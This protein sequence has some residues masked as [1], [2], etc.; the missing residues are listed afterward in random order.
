MKRLIRNSQV[1]Y[2]TLLILGTVAGCGANHESFEKGEGSEG[3]AS[4]AIVVG[5]RGL[6]ARGTTLMAGLTNGEVRSYPFNGVSYYDARGGRIALHP[7]VAASTATATHWFPGTW[8]RKENDDLVYRTSNGDLNMLVYREGRGTTSTI[9]NGWNFTHYVAGHFVDGSMMDLLTRDSAGVATIYSWGTTGPDTTAWIGQR[10]AGTLPDA[11]FF[12]GDFD[13]DGRTDLMARLPNGNLDLYRFNGTAFVLSP[14]VGQGWTGFPI[15]PGDFDGDGKT[16]IL[17]RSPWTGE[18]FMFPFLGTNFGAKVSYGNQPAYDLGFASDFDGDGK[19]D[20]LVRSTTKDLNLY[21]SRGTSL[22]AARQVGNGWDFP[23]LLLGAFETGPRLGA[24]EIGGCS[25]TLVDKGWALANSNCFAGSATPSRLDAL[26]GTTVRA[27]V[28]DGWHDSEHDGLLKL[29]AGSLALV[30]LRDAVPPS[31]VTTGLVT[32]FASSGDARL[33]PGAILRCSGRGVRN[34]GETKPTLLGDGTWADARLRIDSSSAE[35]LFLGSTNGQG[36]AAGDE[37][38][39]CTFDDGSLLAGIVTTAASGGSSQT[40]ATSVAGASG[41]IAKQ[42]IDGNGPAYFGNDLLLRLP[43]G[44]LQ[45]WAWDGVDYGRDKNGRQVG[46][47]WEGMTNLYPGT[48]TRHGR[49]DLAARSATGELWLYPFAGG[50]FGARKLIASTWNYTHTLVGRFT[51]D[52]D[53]DVITRNASGVLEHRSFTNGAFSLPTT[54]LASAPYAEL[55]AADL[56]G[57]GTSDV[58]ARDSGGTL[59]KLRFDPITRTFATPSVIG[60]GFGGIDV[61]VGDFNR[62]GIA[63][64]LGRNAAGEVKLYPFNGTKFTSDYG[65]LVGTGWPAGARYV[66]SDFDHDGRADVLAFTGYTTK[67]A[68]LRT[69]RD[70]YFET[71]Q[72]MDNL[73]SD[74]VVLGSWG[75]GD[76]S[77][78]VTG[79]AT[80]APIGCGSS[81]VSMPFRFSSRDARDWPQL[82]AN[83]CTSTGC[84]G[85]NAE[86]RVNILANRYVSK[87][88]LRFPRLSVDPTDLLRVEVGSQAAGWTLADQRTGELSGT[89]L[90]ASQS[91]S[92]SMTARPLRVTLSAGPSGSAAG[93]EVD[94]V[95]LQCQGDNPNPALLEMHERY[96]GVLL[97]T[98][99][100]VL[101]RFPVRD[102]HQVVTMWATDPSAGTDF[103][104]YARC[105]A[106]PTPTEYDF[107]SASGRADETIHFASTER[108]ACTAGSWYVA[109]HSRRG[110]GQFNL[111][112]TRHAAAQHREVHVGITAYTGDVHRGELTSQQAEQLRLAARQLFSATEGQIFV[113]NFVLH[114]VRE[115]VLS[116]DPQRSDGRCGSP[117]RHCDTLYVWDDAGGTTKSALDGFPSSFIGFRTTPLTVAHEWLHLWGGRT[118]GDGGLVDE[119]ILTGG[120]TGTGCGHSNMAFDTAAL[121]T[122]ADH[123]RDL[124]A[125]TVASAAVAKSA[126]SQLYDNGAVLWKPTTTPDGFDYRDHSF[127]NEQGVEQVGRVTWAP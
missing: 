39:P 74:D 120:S 30:R 42:I 34:H 17:A 52:S 36:T 65:I 24:A 13:G 104:L 40:Q 77:L 7:S 2:S 101:A 99:D 56:D 31:R 29:A 121:C 119:Y 28:A 79:A 55:W 44:R 116:T 86:L 73:G 3:V 35:T 47:G 59:W 83:A 45:Q 18:L 37:G 89:V 125:G 106:F 8:T 102:A 51:K 46:S 78:G 103:D 72:V 90:G 33:L 117:A 20:L 91:P 107:R 69:F 70:T 12:P 123:R 97:G 118:P 49:S 22:T 26:G 66:V 54:A 71:R 21:F 23:A 9:G 111:S 19:A 100:V 82:P 68:T 122:D 112:W 25:A 41:A 32:P 76:A 6:S 114:A 93:F 14:T 57:N 16:D 61:L 60:Y 124:P 48:W 63:D 15:V 126:W 95:N 4:S 109:V 11:E 84:Y 75:N 50:S 10:G 67:A 115:P 108:Q 1:R 92:Q 43:D 110:A 94:R 5:T 81:W 105:N 62:D 96:S 53:V 98:G 88:E 64:V 27:S 87:M 127:K 113:S 80:F 58:L 38:G 85:S